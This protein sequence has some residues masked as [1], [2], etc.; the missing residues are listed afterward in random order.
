MARKRLL[1]VSLL[2]LAACVPLLAGGAGENTYWFRVQKSEAPQPSQ[3]YALSLDYQLGGTVVTLTW[4]EAAQVTGGERDP[5]QYVLLREGERFTNLCSGA[6]VVAGAEILARANASGSLFYP[7]Q[8]EQGKLQLIL[9]EYQKGTAVSL[10]APEREALAREGKDVRLAFQEAG[11]ER[12]LELLLIGKSFSF[13]RLRFRALGEFF[14]GERELFTTKIQ[15]TYRNWSYQKKALAFLNTFFPPEDSSFRSA[16]IKRFALTDVGISDPF[17]TQMFAGLDLS[18]YQSAFR[19]TFVSHFDFR[20]ENRSREGQSTWLPYLDI[21][22]ETFERIYGG[23]R[24]VYVSAYLFYLYDGKQKPL[25]SYLIQKQLTALRPAVPYDYGQYQPL[26]EPEGE[27]LAAMALRYL[28]WGVEYSPFAAANSVQ[29]GGAANRVYGRFADLIRAWVEPE[30]SGYPPGPRTYNYLPSGVTA[31]P[32]LPDPADTPPSGGPPRV[33]V[34]E[35]DFSGTR[36]RLYGKPVRQPYGVSRLELWTSDN[37]AWK[38]SESGVRRIERA[39]SST[40]GEADV[41][42]LYDQK[43]YLEGGSNV[44]LQR[45]N[46]EPLWVGYEFAQLEQVK[47][48]VLVLEPSDETARAEKE[49]FAKRG[50]KL[51]IE[52]KISK[53]VGGQIADVWCPL[54]NDKGQPSSP[55]PLYQEYVYDPYTSS[56]LQNYSLSMGW[57]FAS[58]RYFSH[59]RVQPGQAELPLLRFIYIV[60]PDHEQLV[61][62]VRVMD[63]TGSASLGVAEMMVFPE[64]P[65]AHLTALSRSGQGQII[66]TSGG[67]ASETAVEVAGQ[68]ADKGWRPQHAYY[69]DTHHNK[70]LHLLLNGNPDYAYECSLPQ[71]EALW[72]LEV[73]FAR[74]AGIKS[75][76]VWEK[77][78]SGSGEGGLTA[79]PLALTRDSDLLGS[80]YFCPYD[81][82]ALQG[83]VQKK[84]TTPFAT[85]SRPQAGNALPYAPLGI[86]SPRTFAYK[87]DQQVAARA[88]YKSRFPQSDYRFPETPTTHGEDS[89]QD[90]SYS[91]GYVSEVDTVFA[92]H[93][94]AAA[95]RLALT[96]KAL[97][98]DPAAYGRLAKP[99]VK[100]FLPGWVANSRAGYVAA[101]SP[102]QV[103]KVAGVDALGLLGGSIAMSGLSVEGGLSER[104]LNVWN[105]PVALV[106]DGYYRMQASYTSVPV[107]GRTVA[108]TG[109]DGSGKPVFDAAQSGGSYLDGLYR[110]SRSDLERMSLLVPDIREIQ[111]GD[112]LVRYNV[113]GE[114]HIGIVV[115]FKSTQR[116]AYGADARSW[117]QN[118]LVVSAR[119]GFRTVTLGSWG[120]AERLFGGFSTEPDAYQIRRLVRLKQGGSTAVSHGED[121]W[122]LVRVRHARRYTDYVPKANVAWSTTIEGGAQ[123][124][125]GDSTVQFDSGRLQIL[126]AVPYQ[127]QYYRELPPTSFVNRPAVSPLLEG[128]AMRT[129]CYTGWR[130]LNTKVEAAAP[131]NYLLRY[132][133]GI[134]LGAESGS[135]EGLPILAPED[136]EYWFV[137]DPNDG[138][139][140]TMS[141]PPSN[142]QTNALVIDG[143][144]SGTYA[145]VTLL[146]TDPDNPQAG[147]VYLF[148]HQ[149]IEALKA[150]YP[151]EGAP[152]GVEKRRPVQAGEQIGI[153]G[154]EGAS[155]GA[156]IHLDVYEYFP[157]WQPDDSQYKDSDYKWQRVN[158]RSVFPA[159]WL[160]DDPRNSPD[161]AGKILGSDAGKVPFSNNS[162]VET[163][164]KSWVRF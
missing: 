64:N 120:N 49:A 9:A 122:E 133:R 135:C 3:R 78:H 126:T 74:R 68:E 8:C 101:A 92:Q 106:L 115:G 129:T 98:A 131:N 82:E 79:A 81:E 77:D 93:G 12:E 19:E 13:E 104:L 142:G 42:G 75:V 5:V 148:A 119:R 103:D 21:G 86:D 118:V 146:V 138:D 159:G 112:L 69:A 158:P 63:K 57:S 134:D 90:R 45:V 151:P 99:A 144:L 84:L 132:H 25:L 36:L 157:D 85:G 163:C 1:G 43:L 47:G 62:G 116:P 76:V 27:K 105:E 4:N 44:H 14:R 52:V 65:I 39:I 32:L 26:S 55:A 58:A 108:L 56:T 162:L 2:V 95:G 22:P 10:S 94:G 40:S 117:W 60:L 31:L 17:W 35:G 18:G 24:N 37:L 164:F 30:I 6:E 88:W 110:Y 83:P 11:E 28:T 161:E 125:G 73:A 29:L 89:S 33:H 136:G 124:V 66:L 111:L 150:F 147:R 102:Y 59:W 121:S 145:A 155:Q 70:P 130:D 123:I 80:G 7:L 109:L 72:W 137:Y 67:L 114:P 107:G 143:Y 97:Y 20:Q 23:A 141:L 41:P 127:Y 46:G 153:V 149:S 15:P 113:D 140:L 152:L 139:M 61:K 100:P 128:G 96:E 156:H 38:S 50:A 16:V 34:L 91:E 160:L 71:A 154:N 51:N 87:M 53:A 48:I 54:W